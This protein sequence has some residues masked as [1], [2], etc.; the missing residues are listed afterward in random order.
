MRHYRIRIRNRL[1]QLLYRPKAARS[2][3]ISAE[4]LSLF[5]EWDK[6]IEEKI[7]PLLASLF[8]GE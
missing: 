2:R 5:D 7:T 8:T 3:Y 4:A 6:K 1:L